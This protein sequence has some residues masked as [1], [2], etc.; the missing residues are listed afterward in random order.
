[1]SQDIIQLLQDH[2][3][4]Q[5]ELHE[6]HVNPQM[7]RMLHLVEMDVDYVRSA[8]NY[9]YDS[10]GRQYLDLM[11]HSGVFSVGHNHPHVAEFLKAVLSRELPH[12]LLMDCSLLSGLLAERLL[13]RAPHLGKVYFGNSGAEAVE[14]ALKMARGSTGRPRVLFFEGAYH[15]LTYGAPSV[16]GHEMW[17]GGFAPF[18]PG[19]KAIPFGDLEALARELQKSSSKTQAARAVSN[20]TSILSKR[21]A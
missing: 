9:L 16:V 17:R 14:A 11:T 21:L 5:F 18:L 8:G 6:K 10:K 4:R 19:C 15:G 13:K 12:L 20:R 1:M 2:Q 3:G 7:R